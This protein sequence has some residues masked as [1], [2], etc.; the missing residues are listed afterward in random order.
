MK[1]GEIYFA[2][3]DPVIGS[4]ISKT[5]PVLIVS[6]DINNEFSQTISIL[7]ITSSIGKIYPFEVFIDKAESNLENNSK[8]KANQIRTID[9]IRLIK[10]IGTISK[11]KLNDVENAILIHLGI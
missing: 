7:P 8:I 9:K 6:N 11:K 5:R 2:N 10:Y 1:K 3:L 4:E